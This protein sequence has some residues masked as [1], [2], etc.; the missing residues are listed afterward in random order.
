LISAA[1]VLFVLNTVEGSHH[2]IIGIKTNDAFP[3]CW[4]PP[5]WQ[6]Y[7]R[8]VT[9]TTIYLF[10]LLLRHIIC[11]LSHPLFVPR[12]A[13]HMLR[14]QY[15]RTHSWSDILLEKW[16]QSP[17]AV[18][19]S[20]TSSLSLVWFKLNPLLKRVNYCHIVNAI[21]PQSNVVHP[22]HLASWSN[23]SPITEMDFL[24]SWLW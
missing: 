10:L 13:P 4:R 7:C 22:N 12:S 1:P 15:H 14:H 18:L 16:P 6:K 11:K 21:I 3:Q 17:L 9:F 5:I 8:R 20:V 24:T 23:L 19:S 2:V